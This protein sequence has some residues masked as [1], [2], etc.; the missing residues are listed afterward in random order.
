MHNKPLTP[1]EMYN[2]AIDTMGKNFI[3]QSSQIIKRDYEFDNEEEEKIFSEYLSGRVKNL[4]TDIVREERK[5]YLPNTPTEAEYYSSEVKNILHHNIDCKM[6]KEKTLWPI[7]KKIRDK[8]ID[9]I[10]GKLG[11]TIFVGAGISDAPLKV[12]EIA[13]GLLNNQGHSLT[14]YNFNEEYSPKWYESWQL[15]EKYHVEFEKIFRKLTVFKGVNPT[16]AQKILAQLFQD[17]KQEIKQIVVFNWD[18]LI[19]T[20]HLLQYGEK[21]EAVLGTTDMGDVLVGD[22]IPSSLEI[23][24]PY[25]WHPHGFI[26][27]EEKFIL[28]HEEGIFPD[29]L[30]SFCKEC[31]YGVYLIIAFRD[32]HHSTMSNFFSDVDAQKVIRVRADKENQELT[33]NIDRDVYLKVL[34]TWFPQKSSTP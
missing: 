15:V 18:N 8:I 10:K 16:D 14:E 20:S 26:G 23:T 4:I 32:E 9:S 17:Y 25:I 22:A 31:F 27:T 2:T 30:K 1:L 33:I 19:E 28:P 5:K 29:K 24:K 21:L 34:K 3:N 6:E 7:Y 13:K 12:T 11:L